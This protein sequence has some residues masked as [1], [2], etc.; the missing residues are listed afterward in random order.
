MFALCIFAWG[1]ISD[2]ALPP[3]WVHYLWPTETLLI[4]FAGPLDAS[5]ALL[6]AIAVLLN[7]FVYALVF[8]GVCWG[9]KKAGVNRV[10]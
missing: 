9:I 5:K 6:G 2:S 3:S 10:A 8:S 4:P 7:G 1:H